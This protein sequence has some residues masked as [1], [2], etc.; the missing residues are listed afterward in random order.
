ML[1]HFTALN[2]DLSTTLLTITMTLSTIT[3]QL[4]TASQLLIEYS[5]IV[6]SHPL[7]NQQK[8]FELYL[9]VWKYE[10]LDF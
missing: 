7:M 3:Q 1:C 10:Y 6:I 2:N 8:K 5:N 9:Q 4:P